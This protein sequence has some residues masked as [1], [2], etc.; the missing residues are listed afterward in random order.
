[1]LLGKYKIDLYRSI[2]FCYPVNESN[3]NYKVQLKDSNVG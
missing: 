1:M 3:H 2:N